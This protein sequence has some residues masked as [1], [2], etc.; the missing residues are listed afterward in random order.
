MYG[1]GI[2]IGLLVLA[3]CAKAPIRTE[4]AAPKPAAAATL[5]STA[6]LVKDPALAA[7]VDQLAAKDGI[8]SA[9]IG[10][11]TPSQTFALFEEIA[12]AASREQLLLLLQHQSP[13]VRGYAILHVKE[14]FA[15]ETAVLGPL[16]GDE[17]EVSFLVA[18]MEAEYRLCTLAFNNLPSEALAKLREVLAP[19]ARNVG[20]GCWGDALLGLGTLRD[21][22]VAS[23]AEP[24]LGS[25]DPAIVR[26]A[27]EALQRADVKT[28]AARIRALAASPKERIRADAALALGHFRSAE[29]ELVLRRLID[30][31][32][33]HVRGC[34]FEGYAQQPGRDLG[35][36]QTALQSGN[37][38]IRLRIEIGLAL[39][40]RPDSLALLCKRL[41]ARQESTSFWDVLER[42]LATRHLPLSALMALLRALKANPASEHAASS[43]TRVLFAGCGREC[44]PT[45]RERLQ[46][47][48]GDEQRWA[49]SA[50]GRLN[51]RPSIPL[52]RSLLPTSEPSM[53]AAVARA[54]LQMKVRA[55]IPDIEKAASQLPA[56][57]AD[58]PDY[59]ESLQFVLRALRKLPP[60]GR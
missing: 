20:R 35:L 7:K 21:Q 24:L 27:L 45:F 41:M 12:G 33:A 43:A 36:L 49:A 8:Q 16:L 4:E 38:D 23:I 42:A 1:R 2:L 30:D 57:A 39:D 10:Q 44:L 13:V 17:T 11:G 31:P 9:H 59:K 34:A 55:A 47:G 46:R 56:V 22:S 53:Q 32:E 58:E 3:A 28:S 50:V 15:E 37:D 60:S 5:R 25:E 51:D 19:I 14:H 18:D 48:A 40:A 52:L 54:L 6:E 26:Y 29:S